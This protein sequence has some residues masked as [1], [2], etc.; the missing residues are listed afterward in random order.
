LN[1]AL[2]N[3]KAD[4]QLVLMDPWYEHLDA[5]ATTAWTGRTADSFHRRFVAF[6]YIHGGKTP[7]QQR[8]ILERVKAIGRDAPWWYGPAPGRP[9]ST[10]PYEWG[11]DANIL[12]TALQDT[13]MVV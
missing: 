13:H 9:E 4:K 7:A 10:G 12:A 1:T 11:S 3:V 5:W 6:M 2:W 8:N